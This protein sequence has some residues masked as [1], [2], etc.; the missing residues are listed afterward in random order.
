MLDSLQASAAWDDCVLALTADHGEEFLDHGGT[1]H[2]PD[3]ISEEITRVPLLLRVPGQR[4]QR[5]GS[6]PFSLIHLAPTLLEV[7]GTDCPREFRGRSCWQSLQNGHCCDDPA[8][9]ECVTDAGNAFHRVERLGRRVLAV[10]DERFKLV[11]DLGTKE[12]LFFDLEQDPKELMPTD[13][14][15]DA[16]RRLMSRAQQHLAEGQERLDERLRCRALLREFASE[17]A[18]G[19][20]AVKA[21]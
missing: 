19:R 5:T 7:M 11:W 2:S 14:A 3:N 10:K 12:E 17:W 21:S 15:K 18:S 20:G 1:F 9:T 6:T 13:K 4:C 8:I 16:R